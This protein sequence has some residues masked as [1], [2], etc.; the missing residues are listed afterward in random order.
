MDQI[1]EGCF[2]LFIDQS[3]L[4]GSGDR[5]RAGGSFEDS[6]GFPQQGFIQKDAGALL[7]HRFSS[8]CGYYGDDGIVIC[9]PAR[10]KPSRLLAISASPSPL[11]SGEEKRRGE[12][13]GSFR[14]RLMVSSWEILR[15]EGVP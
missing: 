15:E 13:G 14:A 10:V 2:D 9:L 8:Y 1:S 11:T 4:E 12:E 6:P 5:L 3:F 7:R